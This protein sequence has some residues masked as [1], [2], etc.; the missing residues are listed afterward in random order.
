MFDFH[1]NPEIR[2]EAITTI[3]QRKLRLGDFQQSSQDCRASGGAEL[4]G[5]EH[6]GLLALVLVLPCQALPLK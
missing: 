3:P 4:G 5:D 6:T 1:I 2:R